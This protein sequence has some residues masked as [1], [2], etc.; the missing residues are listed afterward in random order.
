MDNRSDNNYKNYYILGDIIGVGAYG[1]VYK[2]KKKETNE[3]R[4]IKIIDINQIKE[5][6]SYQ[7]ELSELESQMN[8]CIDGFIKEF[9]IMKLCSDN[10]NNSV[11]CYEYFS[12]KES[13]VIIME[14]CDTNLS[15]FLLDKM[16]KDKNY[17]NS[18][19][20][21]DLISPLNKTF[22]IMKKNN[23]IHRDLKLENILIKYD[24]KDH[25]K[26]TIK[27][28]DYGCS[29]RLSSLTKSYCKTNQ[30]TISY[31]APEILKNQVYNYKCDLWSL[32]II[33]YRLFFGKSPFLGETENALISYI[34]KFENKLLKKTGDKDLDDLIKILLEKDPNKRIGWEHYFS[35]PF[36]KNIDN[37]ENIEKQKCDK[38]EYKDDIKL[39]YEAE[40]YDTYQIFGEKFVD[41]NCNNIGLIINGIESE[42]VS[43]FL[44]NKGLN[45]IHIVIL[46]KINSLE[47][48]FINCLSLKNIEEL[49]Y[50]DTSEVYNFSKMFS[51]CSS[52]SD[53]RPLEN[54][55]VSKGKNF[56]E[57][58]KEC[59][60][61]S[62]LDA[63]EK[64]DVSNCYNFSSMFENCSSLANIK[65]LKNWNI[66][67]GVNFAQMF[68]ECIKL[69]DLNGLEYWTFSNKENF[70]DIPSEFFEVKNS[71]IVYMES[72]G[73]RT[74]I[75]NP[76]KINI[77]FMFS[78]CLSLLN[79]NALE[80]WNISNVGIIKGLF[81]NCLSLMDISGL[82][83]WDVSKQNNFS[84]IFNSCSSLKQIK[85]LKNW[86]V[87][88][89]TDFSDMFYNCTSL[90]SLSGLENWN[91]SKA[92]S[93]CGIF[94]RTSLMDVNELLNWNV[95]NV[96][97][98]GGMFNSCQLLSDVN[99]LKKWDVSNGNSFR[100]MFG[101]C[102]QLEDISPLVNWNVSYKGDFRGMFNGSFCLK[103]LK[104]LSNWN[105]SK[106]QF[107][108]MKIVNGLESCLIY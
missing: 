10:N 98:F 42:L 70:D 52:L 15:K 54:W 104:L 75:Q 58:F 47:D 49:K 84:D 2:G 65:G 60:S 93:L 88:N 83:K 67:N 3:L 72:S 87:S 78:K 91:V 74:D 31:M 8:L 38:I 55:D 39:I 22:S 14:L 102:V 59:K 48:M 29:K 64:W 32:G 35:H 53:I 80:N 97:N 40:D 17:F 82:E 68:S 33:L 86:D 100:G 62:N 85:P 89:G 34:E 5:N 7:Y 61:L 79:I 77:F 107:E 36:F 12:T 69:S 19:E 20:I 94:C 4:A 41:N 81:Q 95:S 108:D 13:F 66:S 57:M 37:K 43:E 106:Q 44:L 11:K 105:I 76:K 26:Y 21:L 50:L 99:G 45:E 71:E 92:I 101:K 28:T 73:L 63:L 90:S 103:N 25:K 23:I 27:L 18:K 46:N 16:E 1:R 30:G 24:D 56:S 96:E 9:Q 6:L 51:G